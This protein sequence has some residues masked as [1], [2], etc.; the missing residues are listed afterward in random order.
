MPRTRLG[1]W[2]RWYASTEEDTA[3]YTDRAFRAWAGIFGRAVANRGDLPKLRPLRALYGA[4]EVDFL[5]S[6]GRLCVDGES[7]TI[8]SWTVYQAPPDNTGAE[9]QARFRERHR[10]DS[11]QVD[12]DVENP[13]QPLRNG[14][15]SRSAPTS[16]STSTEPNEE[17]GVVR[18]E[19]ITPPRAPAPARGSTMTAVDDGDR[20]SLDTLFELSGIRPW[21]RRAGNW[22]RDLEGAHSTALVDAAL[23]EEWRRKPDMADLISRVAARL[24]RSKSKHDD[25]VSR[26][27][28]A[29][30][31]ERPQEPR[32]ASELTEDERMA[33]EAGKAA[34][35][36]LQGQLP[37]NGHRREGIAAPLR[38]LLPSTA[39]DGPTSV[40]YLSGDEASNSRLAGKVPIVSEVEANPSLPGDTVRD[41][42]PSDDTSE[43]AIGAPGGT[44]EGKP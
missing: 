38:D 28:A 12:N 13:S 43:P 7:V 31:P 27:K 25:A 23:R 40:G 32:R 8:C 39:S 42:E 19:E 33:A 6:E 1:P 5:I 3:H 35:R 9:R 4:K 14:V 22:L 37:R 26:D 20:D 30:P 10:D 36:A 41:R 44:Q 18:S 2:G 24:E 11:P 16:T 34:W 29:R 15:T 17:T 21:G